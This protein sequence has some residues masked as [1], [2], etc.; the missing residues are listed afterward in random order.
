[1]ISPIEHYIMSLERHLCTLNNPENLEEACRILD[2]LDHFV[3]DGYLSECI[4]VQHWLNKLTICMNAGR[5]N[6]AVAAADELK[7]RKLP[8]EVEHKLKANLVELYLRTGDASKAT[9]AIDELQSIISPDDH[10]AMRRLHAAKVRLMSIDKSSSPLLEIIEML[11]EAEMSGDL[12]GIAKSYIEIAKALMIRFPW[13]G[14]NFFRKAELYAKEIKDESLLREAECCRAKQYAMNFFEIDNPQELDKK[15]FEEAKRII[16][17]I[18][19]ASLPT[20]NERAFFLDIR[21]FI[22]S[23]Y[24]DYDQALSFYEKAGS[25]PNILRISEQ[26][27]MLCLANCDFDKA[28][29]IF[30][31]YQNA[32]KLV[33]GRE[34]YVRLM[35]L[36]VHQKKHIKRQ[37]FNRQQSKGLPTL[38]EVL[39]EISRQEEASYF[40]KLG[41]IFHYMMP[42]IEQEGKFEAIKMP[43]GE[44]R[45]FPCS[46]A[47]NTYYRGQIRRISPSKPSLFRQG[48][49]KSKQYVE[50]LRYEEFKLLVESHPA[51]RYFA[52]N[53]YVQSPSGIIPL[54]L[55]VDHLALAQ[56]YGIK[57]ELLDLTTDKF[58]AAFFACTYMDK[59][60]A[61]HVMDSTN[62]PGVIYVY[63]DFSYFHPK[64]TSDLLPVG[65]QP[66]ARPG[67][68]RGYILK[69]SA[70]DDFD[71]MAKAMEFRQ[72]EESS[73]LIFAYTNRQKRLFPEDVLDKKVNVILHSNVFSEEAR[74]N[75]NQEFYKDTS[76]DV[77]EDYVR[78]AHLKFQ[79]AP[80]VFFSEEEK[81]EF[82]SYI[83]QKS[84]EWKNKIIVR[85]AYSGPVQEVSGE[86]LI[87]HIS[88]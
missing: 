67:E 66:F 39:D 41:T 72:D 42:S 21:A 33:P 37:F 85:L 68:Q 25:L 86:E 18:D 7:R 23:D 34:E 38:L 55:K 76:E 6:D 16:N 40:M 31:K 78:E 12:R 51:T 2:Q 77:L 82:P 27:T 62:S 10:D 19:I 52:A 44:T 1:M 64:S 61:Y 53:F 28:A 50:R 9:Q 59:D 26:Y 4:K 56:H 43:D 5:L 60:G 80:V 63:H 83:Q 3:P 70:S 88:N 32:A 48:M 45:L 17:G 69:M 14:V 57:T 81:A 8:P 29:S 30:V 54:K 22:M 49:T 87:K 13:L 15:A 35:G 46:E 47:V 84:D 36:R 11:G 73:R 65:L 20:E 75:C 71:A 24:K 74:Q 58:V 79:S